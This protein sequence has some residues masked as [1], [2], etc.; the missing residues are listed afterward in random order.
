M[1]ETYLSLFLNS[2]SISAMIMMILITC[3]RKHV[4]G[5]SQFVTLISV[6][7]IWALSSFFET[8]VSGY[9]S[10]LFWRNTTQIGSFLLPVAFLDFSTAYTGVNT[11]NTKRLIFLLYFIQSIFLIL[12]FTDEYT[13]MMRTTIKIISIG[14][15]E[16]LKISSSPLG[17]FAVSLHPIIA[18]YGFIRLLLFMKNTSGV[19]KNQVFIVFWGSLIPF[20]FLWL[21]TTLP[22]LIYPLIPMSTSFFPGSLIILYGVYKYDFLSISPIARNKIFDMV[23]D[24]IVICTPDGRIVD[25]N[26]AAKVLSGNFGIGVDGG[27]YLKEYARKE[28][29]QWFDNVENMNENISE[30]KIEIEGKSRDFE[31]HVYPIKSK[32]EKNIIGTISLIREITEHKRKSEELEIKAH[33]DGLTGILNR[34]AF[35]N[36]FRSV[37]AGKTDRGYGILMIDIDHFKQINDKFGHIYG[38]HVLKG[39]VMHIEESIR[40]ADKIGRI[41]GEEFAILLPDTSSE[42]T[43]DIAERIRQ[44]VEK[45]SFDYSGEKI[46]ITI[47]IGAAHID[48][49]DGIE[50][51]KAFAYIDKL[52]YESKS[53]GR[54]RVSFGKYEI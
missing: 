41:G 36:I 33:T 47:S 15:F 52:L 8:L 20:L 22:S 14:E 17:T 28:F 40:D 49:H 19:S 34:N 50:F 38:D 21:K 35:I 46:S 29:E 51:K 39:I 9:S 12:I 4:R 54:N 53:D 32:N 43:R 11:G 27:A 6:M 16:I 5:G 3:K 48:K 25:Y 18:I 42:E 2:L 24:G 7:T 13:H 10:M 37:T 44:N 23:K 30:F 1:S 26:R 45:K 31:I